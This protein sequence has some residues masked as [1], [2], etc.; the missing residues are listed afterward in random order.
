M[1]QALQPRLSLSEAALRL[2]IHPFD[3]V[4]V[5]VALGSFPDDLHL[6]EEDLARVEQ[7][8]GL[9]TWWAP[10][11]LAESVR[12]AD[13]VPL[14]GMAR[15]LAIQLVEHEVFG[16]ASTRLDNLFRG[17]HP[18][19]QGQARVVLQCMVQAGLVSMVPTPS[20]MNVTVPLERGED[21]IQVARGDSMPESLAKYWESGV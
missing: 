13:P 12:G 1:L 14:R 16:E 3:L 19:D 4:R 8:G 7:L 5:L 6:S 20:G 21:L 10:G 15:A 11:T 17:L 9:E 18:E 2:G